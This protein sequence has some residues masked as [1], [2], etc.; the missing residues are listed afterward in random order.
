MKKLAL[1]GHFLL[2]SIATFILAGLLQTQMV[3]HELIKLNVEITFADRLYMSWQDLLGLLPTYG[4]IVCIGLLIAFAVVKVINTYSRFGSRYLYV[5][6]GGIAMAIILM[7]MQP[8]LG[9]TL[10]AGARSILGIILQIIAGL[11]GGGCFVYLRSRQSS[12]LSSS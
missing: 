9:V 2:A 6:A 11:I 10:L 4:V 12:A 3:L 7:A 1:L 8:V 5:L